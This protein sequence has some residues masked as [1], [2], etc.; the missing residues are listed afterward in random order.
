MEHGR[1]PCETGQPTEYGCV[2]LFS[3]GGGLALGIESAG[4]RH[5]LL[6]ES[7]PSARATI[8]LN[9]R[10]GAYKHPWALHDEVDARRVDYTPYRGKAQLVA[11]GPPC[12]PFSIGGVHRGHLDPR[13]LFPTAIRAV[14][15]IEPAAFIFENVRG[16]IRPAFREYVEY[17]RLHLAYPDLTYRK[18]ETWLEHKQRL[19]ETSTGRGAAAE[20]YS[21]TFKPVVCADYGAPQI[22][23]RVFFVGIRADI[24]SGWRFPER[25]H[26]EDALLAEQY[27][28]G[29]YWS[30]HGLPKRHA[31]SDVKGRV[32]AI[33]GGG[34]RT[35][36]A[37]WQTVRDAISSLPPPARDADRVSRS[38]EQHVFIPGARAYAGH[39]GSRLD[40]PAKAL[41]AGV[42]GIPG[43][44]NMLAYNNGRVRYFTV[45][46]AACLQGFP[47]KYLF[48]G[49]WVEVMRQIGNAVPVMVAETVAR[50]VRD[51]LV[52]KGVSA[53]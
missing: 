34:H 23:F 18:D 32:A 13:D 38:H 47:R 49:A 5:A 7:N 44:E 31:P 4:F 15:E 10:G 22:R 12:Q 27:V 30:R 14:R 48:D 45:R 17:I 35:G 28:S 26:S 20:R 21:V 40:W 51:H 16:L 6:V 11:G 43:G 36:C 25:T 52:N 9:N 53:L 1:K 37:P 8:A 41:K 29:D 3:G 46:E 33:A 42:H 50:S 24:S 19:A 39:T 2:E